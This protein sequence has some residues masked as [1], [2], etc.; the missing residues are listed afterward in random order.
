LAGSPGE[1]SR[2]SE[3]PMCDIEHFPKGAGLLG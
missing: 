1:T 3:I 2:S